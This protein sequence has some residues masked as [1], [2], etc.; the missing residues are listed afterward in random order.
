MHGKEFKYIQPEKPTQ[1]AFLERFNG[2]YRRGA[3]KYIFEDIEQV[4]EQSK[5][6][7]N[8]YN[9]HRDLTRV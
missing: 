6:W 3:N 7:I 2:S 4:R 8:D 5:I 9:H 1:N